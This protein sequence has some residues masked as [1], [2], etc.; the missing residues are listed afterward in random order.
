MLNGYRFLVCLLVGVVALLGIY[1]RTGLSPRPE[2]LLL[3]SSYRGFPWTDSEE[4]GAVDVLQ[5][6]NLRA[7][8]TIEYLDLYRHATPA[9]RASLLQM[10][11]I[12]FHGRHFDV[13]LCT[14]N[15][16]LDFML[17][18]RETLFPDTP[19]VFCGINNFHENLLAGHT[20]YTGVSEAIDVKGTLEIALKL[21]PDTRTITV[22][23]DHARY[24][25][26]NR[27]MLIKV[28]PAFTPRVKFTFL[29][30]LSLE[31]LETK[32]SQLPPHSL[33][34]LLSQLWNAQGEQLLPQA[35][36]QRLAAACPYP[37][38]T[39]WDFFLGNGLVGG[40][41]ISGYSQGAAAA[42]MAVRI[43]QGTPVAAIPVQRESPSE[44]QFDYVA[45][46][47]FHQQPSAL[48]RGSVLFHQPSG[49]YTIHREVIWIGIALLIALTGVV[50]TLHVTIQQRRHVEEKLREA[51]STLGTLIA[52]SPLAMVSVDPEGIVT[53]W[54]PAAEALFGWNE[55]EV[56]GQPL[57]TIPDGWDEMF[58]AQ[59][60]M[61]TSSSSVTLETTRHCKDGRQINV[62]TS[63]TPLFDG[64]GRLIGFMGIHTDITER[65]RLAEQEKLLLVMQEK[66]RVQSEL[67][68]CVSHELK[69]PLT[70]IMAGLEILEDDDDTPVEKRRQ[71]I[72]ILRRQAKRLLYLIND[73]LQLSNMDSG[74]LTYSEQVV[75]LAHLAQQSLAS[76]LP[77]LQ[78]HGLTGAFQQEATMPFVKADPVRLAQVLDN[79]L[80]NAFKYTR[81]GG[82]TVRVTN[83]DTSVRV[84]V[85]D[86]GI[87]IAVQEQQH[88]FERF[89]QID[90][91]QPGAG[92]G[93][94]IVQNYLEACGGS[95]H[96]ESAGPGHGSVFSF[97]VPMTSKSFGD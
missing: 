43:L 76:F 60:K 2:V 57:P 47:R 33:V 73:L 74:Q 37:I 92:L 3:H 93:L 87:G 52:A 61:L 19:V 9:Y 79:L 21:H 85:A 14:D 22:I 24:Y 77:A 95:I 40:K 36:T 32:L 53:S 25:Y 16:A 58:L 96:V 6:S 4:R 39:C 72:R 64:R 38:Y 35:G 56:L 49:W 8:I 15:P 90:P 10:G 55:R 26:D 31:A 63:A 84:E 50:L 44:Y 13:I 81:E 23:G 66:E 65:K 7:N 91:D 5:H 67:L 18:Y 83:E 97:T 94:A 54:N 51:N 75:D 27:D 42:A 71:I 62:L 29:E 70:P 41:V 88:I 30:G 86:T 45:L 17:A 89:Y 48:P 59:R 68:S 11:K 78:E 34:L 80:S 69:T 12:K 46:Q 82:V 28:M 1:A 20:N